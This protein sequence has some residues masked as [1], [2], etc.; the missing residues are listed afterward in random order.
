MIN[1]C[2]LPTV[3]TAI[4]TNACQFNFDQIVKIAFQRT[5]TTASF[6]D[7]TAIQTLSNWTTLK[8]ASDATKIVISPIIQ[9]FAVPKSEPQKAGGNDNSTPFGMPNLFGNG[10]VSP[11]GDFPSLNSTILGQLDLLTQHSLMNSA[12]NS[13]LTMFLFN[14]DGYCFYNDGYF[15]V[16]LFNFIVGTLGSEGLNSKNMN[17]FAMDLKPDWDRSLKSIKVSFDPTSL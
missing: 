3:L 17:G 15:G 10:S 14:K 5:Q 9:N 2:P 4:D 7:D 12:G 8:A 16:E 13:D 6:A 11:A 1:N